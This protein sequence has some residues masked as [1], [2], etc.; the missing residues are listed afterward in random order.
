V[1]AL[2]GIA[3]MFVAPFGVVVAKWSAIRAF[4]EVPGWAGVAAVVAL[5]YGSGATLYY[6][7][8]L[9]MKVLATRKI[10]EAELAIETRVSAYEWFAETTHAVLVGGLA[11]GVGALSSLVVAPWV[12][13]AFGLPGTAVVFPLEPWLAPALVLATLFIP[14]VAWRLTVRPTFDLGG[15]YASG[16]TV[17]AGHV[18][19]AAGGGVRQLATR[20]Y[21]LTGLLDPPRV[22]RAGTVLSAV[23]LTATLLLGLVKS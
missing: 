22:F 15:I 18:V 1:L 5:S 12:T 16:R 13:S 3:G 4:L 11:A 2:T 7:A 8:K 23:V 19:A 9:L 10:P 6:W 17:S 21:Y 14:A 20:N